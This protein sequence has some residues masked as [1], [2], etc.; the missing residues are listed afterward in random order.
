MAI[1]GG[2]IVPGP[3]ELQQLVGTDLNAA[4]ELEM[5][6]LEVDAP[7]DFGAPVAKLVNGAQACILH[8]RFAETRF[9]ELRL[10][11]NVGVQGRCCVHLQQHAS[12]GRSLWQVLIG[13]LTDSTD[14]AGSPDEE[15]VGQLGLAFL[16]TGLALGL[17]KRS[18]AVLD[19]FVHG[20]EADALHRLMRQW[21]VSGSMQSGQIGSGTQNQAVRSDVVTSLDEVMPDGVRQFP[22]ELRGLQQRISELFYELCELELGF[23]YGSAEL[24]APMFAVYPGNG[25]RYTRHYDSVGAWHGRRLSPHHPVRWER[26]VC[27]IIAECAPSSC[28]STRSGHVHMVANCGFM[29]SKLTTSGWRTSQG[30]G[31]AVCRAQALT[32][33]R[34]VN[35]LLISILCMAA[36][37]HSSA[38]ARTHMRYCHPGSRALP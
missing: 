1:D 18:W 32:R 5:W 12:H 35:H 10:P 28:T 19:G 38:T 30:L 36:C 27:T 13:P 17:R 16:A 15:E 8:L 22:R 2:Y 31:L 21:W 4:A 6:S 25:A 26:R 3:R 11:T 34:K 23:D 9:V 14:P 24:Q 37:S 29:P 7:L 33:L 20:W